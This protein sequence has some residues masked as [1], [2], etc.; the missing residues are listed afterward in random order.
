MRSVGGRSLRRR[1]TGEETKAEGEGISAAFVSSSAS[2]S[3][4]GDMTK[5][6]GPFAEERA[7]QGGAHDDRGSHLRGTG[8]GVKFQRPA[9]F[10]IGFGARRFCRMAGLAPRRS[11]R[12]GRG[13][14]HFSASEGANSAVETLGRAGL[15]LIGPRNKVLPRHVGEGEQKIAQ[16][17]LW[18]DH[19]C[20]NAIRGSLLQKGKAKT[21][22][23]AAG[24]AKARVSPLSRPRAGTT[25][26]GMP[27]FPRCGLGS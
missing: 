12:P 2:S 5:P 16:V 3:A 14:G 6:R 8:L 17:S 20:R 7:E 9:E 15:F 27:V 22:F 4:A 24:Q 1:I 18:V 21:R 11:G 19:E 26:K 25:G 13:T 23:A 10:R